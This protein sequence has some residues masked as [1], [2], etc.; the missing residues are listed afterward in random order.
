M[1]I[2]ILAPKQIDFK[3][4]LINALWA[5]IAWVSWSVLLM[6]FVLLSS[7]LN[8]MDITQTLTSWVT[9]T[10]N[11]FFPFFLSFITFFVTLIVLFVTFIFLTFTSPESYARNAISY[12]QIAFMSLLVYIFIT[13]I[14]IFAWLA[15]YNSTIYVFIGHVFVLFFIFTVVLELLNN[16]RYVLVWIY[17]SMVAVLTSWLIA[18]FVFSSFWAGPAKLVSLLILL[19]LIN[20]LIIFIKWICEFLYHKYYLAS[21]NDPLWDIFHQIEL[22]SAEQMKRATEENSI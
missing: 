15:D 9:E 16:Y 11:I 8:I 3:E 12:W 2:G 1:E 18:F 14:Y 7:S 20:F 4:V 22:E 10:R 5:L 17:S 13:P 21:G 19:P 6:V